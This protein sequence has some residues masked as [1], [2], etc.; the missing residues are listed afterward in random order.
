MTSWPM[1]NGGGDKWV[2]HCRHLG[3]TAPFLKC[4]V[5]IAFSSKP[6]MSDWRQKSEQLQL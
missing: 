6:E 2:E 3:K 5:K 4:L 1:K